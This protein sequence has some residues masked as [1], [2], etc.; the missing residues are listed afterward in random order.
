MIERRRINRVKS[1]VRVTINLCDIR[2]DNAPIGSRITGRITDFTPYGA[3]LHLDTIK[4]G[5]HHLFY[6]T[7][8][9]ENHVV[10]LEY[11]ADD[12]DNPVV[13]YGNPAWYD[14]CSS[15]TEIAKFKL[16]IEFLGGQDQEIL[17]KFLAKLAGRQDAEEGWLKKLFQ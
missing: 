9:H 11:R 16:G 3:C 2:R 6:T 13:V 10:S 12:E 7:Q 5:D 1:K 4:C 8:D 17:Q 14:L 15:E